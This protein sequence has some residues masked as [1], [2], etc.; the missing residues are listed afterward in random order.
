MTSISKLMYSGTGRRKCSIAKII[1]KPG[2]GTLII[3]TRNGAEYLQYNPNHL[4]ESLCPLILLG[5][6]KKY[7]IYVKTYGGGL[8]GQ[9]E[10][11][12]LGIARSLCIINPNYRSSLKLE[13]TLKRDSRVKERKKYGLRKARKAPQF[14][15]R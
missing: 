10:A 15:K 12:K 1:L 3:N 9:T 4:K 2:E 5:L 6:E 11:I 7:N 13:G 14:S 8:T